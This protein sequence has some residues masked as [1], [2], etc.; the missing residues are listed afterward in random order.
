MKKSLSIVLFF[1]IYSYIFACTIGVANSSITSDGRALVWKNRDVSS[2]TIVQKFVIDSLAYEFVGVGSENSDYIWMGVNEYG[3][4]IVNSIAS[5]NRLPGNGDMMKWA[6]GSCTNMSEFEDLL[7]QTNETGRETHTNYGV[8]DASGQAKMYEVDV[9][10]WWVFDAADSDGF[11]VRG[12][13]AFHGGAGEEANHPRSIINIEEL[14]ANDNLNTTSILQNQIRDIADAEETISVPYSGFWEDSVPYGYVPLSGISNTGNK[15]AAV[16]QGVLPNEPA[17]LTTM[18]TLL[19]QPSATIAFPIFPTC[20]VP[21]EANTMGQ[22][23]IHYSSEIIY[24]NLFDYQGN[25]IDTY[26][27]HN[28][29][30]NGF[31]DIAL[32]FEEN[33]ISQVDSLKAYWI[34][35][36]YTIQDL[37]NIQDDSATSVLEILENY[38]LIEDPMIDFTVDQ[39]SGYYSIA[40]Q[41]ADI[42]LH[43][44]DYSEWQW[45]FDNDGTIDSYEQNPQFVY[46][47][48]DFDFGQ[49][50]VSLTA[51]NDDISY[52]I[53][54]ENLI[55]LQNINVEFSAEP[56]MGVAPVN[57]QFENM[58]DS[59]ATFFEWDFENDGEID[60]NDENP[61]HLYSQQGVYS[62]YLSSI[63]EGYQESVTEENMIHI[64]EDFS[65]MLAVEPDSIVFET[66]E[67]L[68]GQELT[69]HNITPYPIIIESMQ[70][71]EPY[72]NV[73]Q[74]D[75]IDFPYALAGESSLSLMF[76]VPWDIA[77][78]RDYQIDI[79][80]IETNY[81]QK[82]V[83]FF[84]NNNLTVLQDE[85]SPV[86]EVSL[87]AYP[88]PFNPT[89]TIRF[90]LPKD[91]FV[92]LKI[93]NVLGQKID[94][95]LN[96][97]LPAG[98]HSYEW[99][100]HTE[101]QNFT[102]SGVYFCILNYENRTKSIK[103]LLLK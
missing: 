73:Y 26:K 101:Q 48:P 98:I 82:Q 14:L 21:A 99:N 90:N 77:S 47:Y 57:V 42:S 59:I 41:F 56:M 19:H 15:S 4:A 53:T 39:T 23:Q 62:V 97:Y 22:S 37:Q 64:Y 102:G 46:Q 5:F 84:M 9:A 67:D 45:D 87:R 24:E 76:Y 96:Q 6:L 18:W 100:G 30:E 3:F 17:E 80:Q 11:V 66:Q 79:L 72:D 61:F 78:N 12:N 33:K 49:Y 32:N 27:L 52:T 16:I 75:A 94:T 65:Q 88:N 40:V 43:N 44:P 83:S 81:G 38:D 71:V 51:I 91:T 25:Y 31:W 89:T 93:Y 60:S 20:D 103:L 54:K 28:P 34:E 10:Q 13:A 36:G 8:I 29:E 50:S 85:S 2:P 86:P 55:N 63:Y 7:N 70:F 69:I 1:L 92:S 35:N 58:S 95:I 74:H 68:Y